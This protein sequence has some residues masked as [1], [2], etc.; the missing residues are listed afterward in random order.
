MNAPFKSGAV[1]GKSR[2]GSTRQVH[3]V[4]NK[5]R[6]AFGLDNYFPVDEETIHVSVLEWLRLVL[7][8]ALVVHV[9]NGGSRDVR[10]AVKLK[11]MG[12][13]A[14]IPDLIVFMDGAFA[15]ALEIKT[16]AGKLSAEQL[17]VHT[18][19]RRLGFKIAVVRGIEE[20][21]AALAAW[22]V[23]TREART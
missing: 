17:G 21:R 7:P 10:E 11:R 14:G 3:V 12:V 16:Q 1:F 22:G 18:V 9:P 8:G 15:F 13:V 2:G 20:A 19:M 4:V 23:P 5:P 6:K